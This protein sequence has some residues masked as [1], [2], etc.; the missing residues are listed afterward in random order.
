M[1]S[2]QIRQCNVRPFISTSAEQPGSGF[3]RIV[4]AERIVVRKN[5]RPSI[6]P[7]LMR[8]HNIA[9]RRALIENIV[10]GQ[11]KAAVCW[12]IFQEQVSNHPG[13]VLEFG[14]ARRRVLTIRPNHVPGEERRSCKDHSISVEPNRFALLVIYCDNVDAASS[15]WIC[16]YDFYG[17]E[18]EPHLRSHL[19]VQ[20]GDQPA[21]SLRPGHQGLSFG[22]G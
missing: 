1:S 18:P 8:C 14:C 19:A 11:R 9:E 15:V 20:V 21:V 5:R 16:G 12:S 3:A 4:V 17:R 7:A 6:K 13:A 22:T 10:P 2:G